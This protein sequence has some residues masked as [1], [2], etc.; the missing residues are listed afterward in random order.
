M[1]KQTTIIEPY[2]IQ[3]KIKQKKQKSLYI[4]LLKTFAVS[5]LIGVAYGLS[6]FL[7]QTNVIIM[8][9][10]GVAAVSYVY[11]TNY[12]E[13]GINIPVRLILGFLCS[14]QIAVA[15]LVCE[16]AYS[17]L[18][19]YSANMS[20]I[21]SEYMRYTLENPGKQ[22]APLFLLAICFVYGALQDY[23]I[24]LQMLI[25]KLFMRKLGKYYYKKEGH[26]VSIYIIDP[27]DYDEYERDRLIAYVTEGCYF[28]I[29][30]NILKAFYL[31]KQNLDEAEIHIHN[32]GIVTI[33]EAK[34]YMLDFGSTGAC[35]KYIAPCA[36]VMDGGQNVEVVQIEI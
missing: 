17:Q 4:A 11:N 34:Y 31:S 3:F 28:E 13:E 36:L 25:R 7:L 9:I 18:P 33:G 10:I 30:K 29:Q 24:R 21:I 26:M 15:F 35:K 6:N 12:Y 8:P 22:A 19:L 27:M 14:L 32:D 16:M 2:T 20:I 5:C 23:T 1:E